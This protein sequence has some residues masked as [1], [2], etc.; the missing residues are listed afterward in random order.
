MTARVAKTAALSSNS[1]QG[2]GA[3]SLPHFC[4]LSKKDA[5]SLDFTNA[6]DAFELVRRR[7]VDG[8]PPV[9]E[10][11]YLDEGVV[12]STMSARS[13]RCASASFTRRSS[14]SFSSRSA[15]SAS[16]R[17]VVSEHAQNIPAT[18]PLSSRSGE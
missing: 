5:R 9:L 6:E 14:V 2:R 1:K 18:L 8:K 15:R 17:R 16:T 7:P 11:C 3:R 10:I 4:T 13:L 12:P